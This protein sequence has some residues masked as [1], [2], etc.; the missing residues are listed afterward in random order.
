VDVDAA[1]LSALDSERLINSLVIPRPIAWVTTTDMAGRGNLAPFSYFN[2][3]SSGPP[4]A[5]MISFSPKGRKDT[6]HNLVDTGEFVVNVVSDDLR[7]EMVASS[8]EFGLSID[9]A[10]VLGLG[11]TPSVKVRPPRLAGAR[12][13]LECRTIGTH[14]VDSSTVAFGRVVHLYIAD[15]VLR[16]GRVDPVLLA[17]VGRLGGNLYTTVSDVYR[18]SRPNAPVEE[19]SP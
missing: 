10:E 5:V 9:E 15:A 7:E 6:L 18:I 16:D 14:S 8:A 11:M 3:V 13:A 2:V 4:P 12:T 1:G 19:G 17:P